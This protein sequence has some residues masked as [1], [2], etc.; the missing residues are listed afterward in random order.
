MGCPTA[1][2]HLLQPNIFGS[3]RTAIGV[4]LSVIGFI[5]MYSRLLSAILQLQSNISQSLL[6]QETP[7]SQVD[8][9]ESI[10]SDYLQQDN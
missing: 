6:Q 10:Y 7:L 8:Y 3:I 5:E 4:G 1:A 9:V 2:C